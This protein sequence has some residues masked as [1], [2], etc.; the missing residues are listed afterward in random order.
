MVS[1]TAVALGVSIAATSLL[2]LHD[3]IKQVQ[4][5]QGFITYLLNQKIEEGAQYALS[6]L[7]STL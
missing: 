6:S 7:A 1:L 2:T 5:G 3:T 4:Y